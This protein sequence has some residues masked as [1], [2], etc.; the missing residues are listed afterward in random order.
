MTNTR[1]QIVITGYSAI[2]A[3]G[4]NKE[5][6]VEKLFAGES[7]IGDTL[8]NYKDGE[9]T[10][11]T[12]EIR[13][14]L[15]VDGFFAEKDIIPNR[16]S[17]LTLL[18][19]EGSIID[20]GISIENEN[21]LRVGIVI[22]TALGGMRSGEKFHTEWIEN[23]IENAD[24]KL[25][26]QYP[27]HAIAD[28]VAMKY[29]LKGAKLTVS[30]ACSSGANAIGLGTDLINGDLCDVVI[31]GGIDPLSRFS[32][33]GFKALKAIDSTKCK[34]YSA[35]KGI[36]LGEASAFFILESVEHAQKRK[37]DIKAEVRGYGITADA[38]HPTAPES[39]GK[40]AV[41]SMMAAMKNSDCTLD[42]I[43]YINGHGTGTTANDNSERK[44][45]KSF[46]KDNVDIP[47]ISNKAAAGHCMGA[48]G[49]LELAFSVMSLEKN[50][51]PPTVNFDEN[52]LNNTDEIDFVPN[53][54]KDCIVDNVLS[55]SF[56]FG[57]NN[58]SV[59]ISK[60]QKRTLVNYNA[61]DVVITGIGAI[62]V[63]GTDIAELFDT[64][65]TGKCWITEIDVDGKDFKT[66]FVG[67]MPEIDLKK[68]IPSKIIRRIDQVTKLAMSSGKQALV[69]SK[70]VI[71]P[72]N[73]ERVGVIYGTGTGPLETIEKVSRNMIIEGC[74][75][76]DANIFPNT[77]LNAAPG[78]FSITNM[79]KGPI[80]T[81]SSGSVSC[82]DAF[83]YATELLK[84]DQAD[85][86]VVISSDEWNE[87]LQIGNEKLGLLTGKGKLPFS[88]DSDGM[89]LSAGSTAFVLE[90]KKHAVDRG[91]DIKA[92]V[93]G[94]SISSDNSELSS[95]NEEG[96]EWSLCVKN[97]LEKAQVQNVDYYAS[98]A[99]G[100]PSVDK[101]ELKLIEDVFGGLT[102]VRS[103]VRLLGSTS[104]SIGGY[105]LLSC[106]YALEKGKA[107]SAGILTDDVTETYKKLVQRSSDKKVKIAIVSA[108]SF[109]G[110]Y[111]SVVIGK[112]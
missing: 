25:L 16:A 94:Y 64:F 5:E 61:D 47:M 30:T 65:D 19:V 70:L 85:V 28:I 107:P 23:G 57:G 80:S 86:I 87:A 18:S 40:G 98:T 29:S 105:G 110:S 101:K 111:A 17:I 22:G 41:R 49:A 35:S 82:L 84:S 75:G 67:K 4:I 31:A 9:I 77:V 10:T 102:A 20:S 97:A 50:Q 55:N 8:Y 24:A 32:F 66:P 59:I 51:I 74:S 12:G 13:K 39:T 38:Y 100:I 6:N 81:I 112:D 71:T 56:A 96:E 58:C 72:L 104:G 7:G 91:A 14:E 108:A 83:I 95:I 93:L 27:L 33:A 63:G 106:I 46:V 90:R 34:P 68:Y 37:A 52:N 78:N 73:A 11:A 2:S 48:A 76:V 36:N 21:P 92:K 15:N 79:L 44:A 53:R 1:K 60:Y 42:E 62:G 103:T 26:N 54:A 109:G 89:I 69:D 99:F 43:T 45:W 88:N 3:L